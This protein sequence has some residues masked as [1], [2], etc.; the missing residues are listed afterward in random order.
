MIRKIFGQTYIWLIL[1]LLYLPILVLM[2]FSFTDAVYVGQWTGFT[3]DLFP[4]LFQNEDIMRALGNTVII[5]ICSA[6]VS[7]VLGT[8]G[9]IGAFYSK[10]RTRKLVDSIT[11]IPIVNAEIVMALSLTILFV[12]IRDNIFGGADM[13]SFWTLLIGHVVLSLPFVYISVKPKLQQMDPSLYEAALDLGCKPSKA[14]HKVVLPE[15][16]PGILSG[17]MLALTLSLDDFIITAFTRGSGLLN[18]GGTIETL[19]TYIQ[20]IIKKRPVPPEMRALTTL[21]FIGVIVA[22]VLVSLY[23]YY[24]DKKKIKSKTFRRT[25]R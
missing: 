10:K 16:L 23:R 13:F 25:A 7:T 2:A 3:F 14:L 22:V 15:I 18:G 4:K 6:L 9:A 21:I 24:G 11:Q 1:I 5:A 19:S 12:F 8:L 20:A 17:F